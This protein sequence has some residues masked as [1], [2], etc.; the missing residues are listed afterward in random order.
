MLILCA[1]AAVFGVSAIGRPS[2]SIAAT[3]P[4]PQ[5]TETVQGDA[6]I[7]A[8]LFIQ[9]RACHTVDR[10]GANGVGPNLAGVMG[11]KGG[12]HP[13]YTYSPAM[14]KA[15]LTWTPATMDAWLKRP[16]ALVPGTK[17]SFPGMSSPKARADMIAYLR[18]LKK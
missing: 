7:G 2:P 5:T 17:M 11:A 14:S 3:P 4:P 13:G 15:S 9:C 12:F 16:S 6:A 1:S 18:T 8:K 10:G